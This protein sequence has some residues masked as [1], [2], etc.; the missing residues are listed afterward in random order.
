M[1]APTDECTAV[2]TRLCV[3][4]DTDAVAGHGLPQWW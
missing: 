2:R 1:T 3:L 4:E